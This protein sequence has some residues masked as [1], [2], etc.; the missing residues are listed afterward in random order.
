[1][2]LIISYTF[3]IVRFKRFVINQEKGLSL[4]IWTLPV[5][6]GLLASLL[7]FF[8][9][10]YKDMIFDLRSVPIF[11]ATY[12]WGW[13]IGVLSIILPGV[14]RFY[15]GGS[16]VWYGIAFDILMPFIVGIFFSIYK[17]LTPRIRMVKV[18]MALFAFTFFH[19]L[20]FI[21]E[22][23]TLKLPYYPSFR[24]NFFLLIFSYLSLIGMMLIINDSNNLILLYRKLNFRADYDQMTGL[25]KLD[26][27]KRKAEEFIEDSMSIVMVDIDFFKEYNDNNGHLRGDEALRTVAQLLKDSVRVDDFVA[28]YGGEEFIICLANLNNIHEAVTIAQRFRQEIEDYSFE[29]ENGQPNNK[30]TISAGISYANRV[31]SLKNLEHLIAKADQALYYSKSKG[32]NMVSLSSN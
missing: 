1:M 22:R 12:L 14:Y 30:L 23:L 24:I 31:N 28:R 9:V 13:K 7:M 5:T 27:F 3:L 19:L 4:F 26:S 16:I 17:S 21:L 32:R 10:K 2:T 8:S 18:G 6:V 15:L 20:R 25:L 29:G 11:L